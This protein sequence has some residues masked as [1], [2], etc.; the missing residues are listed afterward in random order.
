MDRFENGS[1][2]TGEGESWGKGWGG[3]AIDTKG[4]GFIKHL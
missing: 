3:R 4:N 2:G 1:F